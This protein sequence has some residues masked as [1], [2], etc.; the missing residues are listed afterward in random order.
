MTDAPDKM[1][2]ERI[3]PSQMYPD[4]GS[5]YHETP[6]KRTAVEYIRADLARPMTVAEAAKVRE[7]L[8]R[9]AFELNR[10]FIIASQA[11]PTQALGVLH[12]VELILEKSVKAL[13]ALSEEP[14]A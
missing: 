9:E 3:A 11:R 13:R 4:G 6:T 14:S 2:R 7:G 8:R 1:W 5:F 10:A 12:K